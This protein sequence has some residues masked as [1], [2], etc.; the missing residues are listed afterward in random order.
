MLVVNKQL[1]IPASK[2]SFYSCFY[3]QS[4]QG[5]FHPGTLETKRLQASLSYSLPSP[6]IFKELWKS[7]SLKIYQL[8]ES[9][10]YN[11]IFGGLSVS[12]TLPLIHLT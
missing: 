4:F 10:T 6:L 2:Q 12:S 7:L 8:H 1:F 11:Q 3:S 9:P 5:S